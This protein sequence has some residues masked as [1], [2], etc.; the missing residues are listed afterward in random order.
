MNENKEVTYFVRAFS[1]NLPV[2]LAPGTGLSLLHWSLSTGNIS[3]GQAMLDRVPVRPPMK[4]WYCLMAFSPHLSRTM[5]SVHCIQVTYPQHILAWLSS[6]LPVTV[7]SSWFAVFKKL[8]LQV[9]LYSSVLSTFLWI[10]G[11]SFR[12]AV[13]KD[14]QLFVIFYNYFF[15]IERYMNSGTDRLCP[16]CLVCR[17]WSIVT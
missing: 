11:L 15:F 5:L 13:G 4:F 3:L 17:I 14:N 8:L 6:A 10:Q 9:F 7:S 16:D 12:N 2:G 1:P